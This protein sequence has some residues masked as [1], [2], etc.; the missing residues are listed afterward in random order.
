MPE[1]FEQ[2]MA[3]GEI[4]AA[5]LEGKI[6]RLGVNFGAPGDRRTRDGTLWLDYPSVGGPSPEISVKTI[7]AKPEFAYRHSIWMKP[8]KEVW[9][10]VASSLAKNLESL[11]IGGFKPGSYDVR[12]TFV[13][14]SRDFEV[15]INGQSVAISLKLGETESSIAKLSSVEIERDLSVEFTSAVSLAGIE[16]VSEEPRQT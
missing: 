14:T 7:P 4:P 6:Q 5:E 11:T 3:W 16:V 12:L 9:P 8:S 15:K 10:W 1:S 2:W 13:G